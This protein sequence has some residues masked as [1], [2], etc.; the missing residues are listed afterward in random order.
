MVS[1]PQITPIDSTANSPLPCDLVHFV[2]SALTPTLNN[3]NV[4]FTYPIM[5]T[6]L[7]T[8]TTLSLAVHAQKDW[9]V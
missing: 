1:I 7:H 4:M 6:F 9:L 8:N 5:P 2:A 3:T